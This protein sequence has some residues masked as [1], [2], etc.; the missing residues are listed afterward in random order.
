MYNR[1]QPQEITYDAKSEEEIRSAIV[2][3]LR[4]SYDQAIAN[5]QEQTRADKANLDADAIARGM[6]ASTY[7]T[8]VKNRQQNAEARDVATLESNYGSTLADY[9]SKGVENETDRS[10]E[11]QKFNAEQRQK[12]YEMAYSAALVLFQQYKKRSGGGS[13]RSG[14]VTTTSRE[15]CDTFLSLLSGAERREVYEAPSGAGK[16]YRSE[17]IASVGSAGYYQLMGKYPSTP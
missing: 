14:K 3:W 10:L 2:T 8:D 4:P 5:R 12:A 15:N 1:F 7:V 6:G 16:Q 17:I 9:V 11:T 13:G